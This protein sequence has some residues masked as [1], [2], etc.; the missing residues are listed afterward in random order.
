M[1]QLVL[2]QPTVGE[3]V[4]AIRAN[5]MAE[6]DAARQN[7]LAMLGAAW[8]MSAAAGR[9]DAGRT[10][11]GLRRNVEAGQ[12]LETKLD[13]ISVAA[14]ADGGS[15]VVTLR[16]D[17][18]RQRRFLGVFRIGEVEDSRK[19][20]VT[21]STAGT[22]T[23]AGRG[24]APYT[25]FRS[26]LGEFRSV[27]NATARRAAAVGSQSL[28]NIYRLP[29]VEVP[30]AKFVTQPQDAEPVQELGERPVDPAQEN[31]FLK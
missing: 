22:A 24:F 8:S 11:L 23:I 30:Q 4:A 3:V 5:E 13:G 9:Q 28:V 16:Q 7:E 15:A 20:T 10:V 17:A 31:A 19:I 21:I 29:E 27:A 14:T 18:V 6:L 1:D 25:P 2:E 12:G 26:T